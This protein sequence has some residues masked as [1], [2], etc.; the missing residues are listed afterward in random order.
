MFNLFSIK[1]DPA[2]SKERYHTI[3]IHHHCEHEERERE[4]GLLKS[5]N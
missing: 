5:Q 4:Q 1:Y 3:D 2:S